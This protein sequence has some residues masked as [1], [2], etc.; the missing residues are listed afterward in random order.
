MCLAD[1]RSAE[2]YLIGV[3]HMNFILN[4]FSEYGVWIIRVLFLVV[5]VLLVF[6]YFHLIDVSKRIKELLDKKSTNPKV[7]TALHEYKEETE[8]NTSIKIDEVRELENKFNELSSAHG[9]IAQAIPLFP[10][11]GILGTVAGLM[12]QVQA[13]DIQMMLD[14]LDTALA[15]TFTGLFYAIFLKII[16]IFPAKVINDVEVMLDNFDRKLELAEM[17][18]E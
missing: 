5:F 17:D 6:N 2:N 12:L 14:S 9:A 4:L 11:L 18:K 15:T 7:N 8:E 3:G 1:A 13:E 10:M 16:D